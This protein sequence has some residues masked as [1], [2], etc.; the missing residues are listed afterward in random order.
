MEKDEE[1]VSSKEVRDISS[2][3]EVL[4]LV[5]GHCRTKLETDFPLS[6]SHAE[7]VSLILEQCAGKLTR[8]GAKQRTNRGMN[9][10]RHMHTYTLV[11]RR[12]KK[13]EI[14]LKK[15]NKERARNNEIG[16]QSKLKSHVSRTRR[17]KPF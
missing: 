13:K 8:Y 2:T 14:Q 4:C 5:N 1:L 16:E 10:K 12:P 15:K 6:S 3:I 17:F 9:K 11:K 7:F